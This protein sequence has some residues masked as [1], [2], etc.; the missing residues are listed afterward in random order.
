MV[1][2]LMGSFRPGVEPYALSGFRLVDRMGRVHDLADLRR[3]R[4]YRGELLPGGTLQPDDR[5]ISG[6]PQPRKSPRPD[7]RAS[8]HLRA[9]AA[10]QAIAVALR[11]RTRNQP[12]PASPEIPAAA[13]PPTGDTSGLATV[14][15]Q[16]GAVMVSLSRVTAPLLASMLPAIVSP[17]VTVIEARARM[18]PA[19]VEPVP[20]VAEL[21]TC[22]KTLQAWA[23]LM[24]LMALAEAVVSVEPIW[25]MKTAFWLFCPSRVTVPLTPSD[26]AAL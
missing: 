7:G 25:K 21:P 3:E 23:P 12:S 19:K 4:Q 17:V 2:A 24:R 20:S 6:K 16:A 22:Q 26:D 1:R 11:R 18:L 13:A 5:R 8:D 15:E 14:C 9:A 10:D